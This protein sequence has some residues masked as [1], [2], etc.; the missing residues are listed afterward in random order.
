MKSSLS[1]EINIRK[2]FKLELKGEWAAVKVNWI[3]SY[4][5]S[6]RGQNAIEVL[7]TK[8]GDYAITFEPLFRF[9]PK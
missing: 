8:T 2:D 4:L 1:D 5:L 6:V 3:T 9:L 7:L